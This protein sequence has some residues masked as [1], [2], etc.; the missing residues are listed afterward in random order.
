MCIIKVQVS[1]IGSF[2]LECY[3]ASMGAVLCENKLIMT[4]NKRSYYRGSEQERSQTLIRATQECIV[5]GGIRKATIRS[6]AAEARVT[7]GLI[8]H[9]FPGKDELLCEA[10]RDTMT[11]MTQQ[12]MN[13]L[14]DF[15]GSAVERLHV[16]VRTT[17]SPPVM[18]P[19]Q[20]QLWASFTSLIRS[21]PA[22]AEV[23]RVSYLE[24]RKECSNLVAA[25]FLEQ[26]LKA[27]EK[28]IERRAIALNALLDGF[29]IEGCLA[30]E[31][32]E[33]GE[34]ADIGIRSVNALLDLN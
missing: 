12:T 16:F 5:Q 9:Y 33:K 22:L 27:N 31:L 17:L 4:T 8:R 20:H 11:T 18:S 24:F 28:K 3:S 13:A 25:V 10:Y 29:W 21:M 1:A 26:G 23:H 7:P 14:H 6:I 19:R 32:F 15:N 34:I 30:V 2:G